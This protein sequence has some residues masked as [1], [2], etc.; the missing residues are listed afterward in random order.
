MT[1]QQKIDKPVSC[2]NSLK[3]QNRIGFAATIE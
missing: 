2:D 3:F 1:S